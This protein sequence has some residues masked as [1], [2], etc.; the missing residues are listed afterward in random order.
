M[1]D[2]GGLRQGLVRFYRLPPVAR[3]GPSGFSDR[4]IRDRSLRDLVH[5]QRQALPSRARPG[6]SPAVFA[7]GK[8]GLYLS[9]KQKAESKGS[10]SR[11]S[12]FP[13]FRLPLLLPIM[14]PD[15]VSDPLGIEAIADPSDFQQII[16][17]RLP[18]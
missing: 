9:G 4:R 14:K 13:L 17:E 6:D 11:M 7:V 16:C 3:I 8:N 18:E 10:K 15:P 12:P 2:G 1:A 5:V